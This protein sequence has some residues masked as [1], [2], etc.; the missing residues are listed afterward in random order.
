VTSRSDLPLT[1]A[2]TAACLLFG[3]RPFGGRGSFMA[4]SGYRGEL[5]IRRE[6]RAPQICIR[7]IHEDR[8]HDAVMR[9]GGELRGGG[10]ILNRGS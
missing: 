3:G 4:I 6:R 10:P 2:S 1:V 8:H 9:I 5:A 7:S